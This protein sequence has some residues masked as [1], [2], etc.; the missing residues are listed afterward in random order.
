VAACLQ[1]RELLSS[2]GSLKSMSLG[3]DPETGW[4]RGY[5]LAEYSD[6]ATARVA[7]QVGGWGAD[8]VQ[9]RM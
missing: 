4:P 5:A 6:P 7:L 8:V 3:R 2:F 1:V 9:P